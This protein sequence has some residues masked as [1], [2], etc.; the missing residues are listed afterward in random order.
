MSNRGFDEYG[1]YGE[2]NGPLPPIKPGGA[3]KAN[4]NKGTKG[5]A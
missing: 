3:G 2:N 1:A 4:T 5:K